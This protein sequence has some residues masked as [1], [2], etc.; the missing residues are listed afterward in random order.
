[1]Q[2]KGWMILTIILCVVLAGQL[3]YVFGVNAGTRIG[4]MTNPLS[5][6]KSIDK[7]TGS[8]EFRLPAGNAWNAAATFGGAGSYFTGNNWYFCND[9]GWTYTG[10]WG[11]S[12]PDNPEG[13]WYYQ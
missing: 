1:M 7:A 12:G 4:G 6:K 3:V 5:Q 11:W 8:Y 10:S 13:F 2:K 9:S